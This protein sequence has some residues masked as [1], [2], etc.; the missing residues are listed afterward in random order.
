MDG[1][2]VVKPLI[3]TSSMLVCI[4]FSAHSLAASDEKGKEHISLAQA[5]NIQD[6]RL[7]ILK[8]F[9]SAN[10]VVKHPKLTMAM[11][12]Q[13]KPKP[14]YILSGQYKA[15]IL[16]DKPFYFHPDKIKIGIASEVK[17]LGAEIMLV[18]TK[19]SE[20][21]LRKPMKNEYLQ[22]DTDPSWPENI[23]VVANLQFKNGFDVIKTDVTF[24]LPVARLS[25][26][27]EPFVSED[28]I[29]IP[30]KLESEKKGL[31]R[32][33]G[34]LF[35]ESGIPIISLSETQLIDQ[36]TNNVAMKVSKELIESARE[37]FRHFDVQNQTL[38]I[39]NLA[40][41]QVCQHTGKVLA[42]GQSEKA[43]IN[44]NSL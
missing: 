12:N 15:A 21:L 31:F 35:N 17:T 34:F 10:R 18:D 6:D 11:F 22:I 16:L 25:S 20:I 39:H 19:K 2:V 40:V 5:L 23:R 41:E 32:F 24:A 38:T 3:L 13:F 37:K 14:N 9:S 36:G 7:T 30:L 28:H 44:L 27:K 29:L 8:A 42:Q 1:K 4:W 26:E 43:V 33:K